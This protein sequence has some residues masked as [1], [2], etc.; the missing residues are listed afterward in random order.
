MDAL[1]SGDQFDF[2]GSVMIW[3]HFWAI[4]LIVSGATFAGITIIVAWKGVGDL[5]VMFRDLARGKGDTKGGREQ[6]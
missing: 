6:E 1:D 3:I 2:E 4:W 5:R